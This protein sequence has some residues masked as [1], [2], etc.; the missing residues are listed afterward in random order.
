MKMRSWNKL[1][2]VGLA[3]FGLFI[4]VGVYAGRAETA[5]TNMAPTKTIAPAQ[6]NLPAVPAEVLRMS[7]AGMSEDV[8]T[9]YIQKS[10]NAYT[11]DADQI[12][13]LHDVGVSSTVLNALVSHG[14]TMANTPPAYCSVRLWRAAS[15]GS[16]PDLPMTEQN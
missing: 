5:G 8:I 1:A 9:S 4:A 16:L 10:D 11:L 14:G 2:L 13:Y 6:V 7:Q 15:T 12:I 3:A